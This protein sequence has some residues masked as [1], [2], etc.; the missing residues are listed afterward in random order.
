MHES[1]VCVCVR[2]WPCT[3]PAETSRTIVNAANV[4]MC[5]CVRVGCAVERFSPT[6]TSLDLPNI[7]GAWNWSRFASTKLL[8]QMA[9]AIDDCFCS[10]IFL[11]QNPNKACL[12]QPKKSVTSNTYVHEQQSPHKRCNQSYLIHLMQSQIQR[13][14]PLSLALPLWPIRLWLAPSH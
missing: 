2:A 11:V 14:A 13:E 6:L 9:V 5:L 1:C 7:C 8:K 4:C 12:W 10:P 3:W